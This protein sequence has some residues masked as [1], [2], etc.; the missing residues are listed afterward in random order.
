MRL[1]T[2]AV[3]LGLCATI[4]ISALFGQQNVQFGPQDDLVNP[5]DPGPPPAETL[6]P[7]PFR[8]NANQ[9]VPD[10]TGPGF[11]EVSDQDQIRPL[12]FDSQLQPSPL[13]PVPAPI[14]TSPNPT[15]SPFSSAAAS[16]ASTSRNNNN[17]FSP[18][19]ARAAPIMGDSL[20]PS[21]QFIDPFDDTIF[22]TPTGGGAT[23]RKIAE[24]T[25]ALPTDRLIFNY[26][27]FQNAVNSGDRSDN[28]DR[29]TLGFEKTFMDGLFSIDV[30]FPL[31]AEND[32]TDSNT[33]FIRNGSE[34]GNLSTVLKV[35]LASDRNYAIAAGLG[36]DTPT[37]GD[38][39]LTFPSTDTLILRNDAVHLA[40]F[41]GFLFAQDGGLTHQ[42]FLQV[43]VPTNPNGIEFVEDP[44]ITGAQTIVTDFEE[45]TLLYIDYSLSKALF[46]GR[47]TVRRV[48]GLVEFHYTTTLEDSDE[49]VITSVLNPTPLAFSSQGN[50]ID[51]LN[52]TLGVDTLLSCGAN[53]RFGTVVPINDGDD[54]FFDVEFLAQVNFPL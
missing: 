5:S 42:A 37:G 23:R 41:L 10:P 52:L 11:A 31:T 48:T 17:S 18:R 13:Q 51:V 36:I 45:Q 22:E 34:V 9:T 20:P 39:R 28:I 2:I 29:Y 43:D 32:F 14:T 53:L 21:L 1:S 54:R 47:D 30:R 44:T 50:R 46:S 38:T 27:N 19:L 4:Q 7:N 25:G 6:P 3:A 15:P 16:T 24:N 33:G 12:P 8:N 49:V 40:P 35:L 26:N